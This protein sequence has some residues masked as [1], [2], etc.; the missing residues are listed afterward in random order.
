MQRIK[1]RFKSI[2]AIKNAATLIS[3]IRIALLK[4][5]P[6]G[7]GLGGGSA[8]GAGMLTLLNRHFNLQL[9]IS[10]LT[11][12]AAQLGDDCPFFILNKPA[13]VTGRGENLEPISLDLSQY[14]FVIVKPPIHIATAWA[15]AQINPIN[16]K[17]T[18]VIVLW[19]RYIPGKSVYYNDFEIPIFNHYPEIMQIKKNLYQLGA[20]YSQMSGSG[21]AVYGIFE[22]KPSIDLLKQTF[23]DAKVILCASK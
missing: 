17:L 19:P 12:Y 21:S 8:D 22:T 6:T 16:G 2:S 11:A 4:N 20:V 23:K 3:L 15:F 14:H 13:Y 9:N 1:H 18:C 10:N 5:I 7:A